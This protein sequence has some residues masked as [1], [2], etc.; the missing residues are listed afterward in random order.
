MRSCLSNV[1]IRMVTNNSFCRC[2]SS[3]SGPSS[4]PTN[5]KTGLEGMLKESYVHP[6]SQ[7]VLEHL[8]TNVSSKFIIKAFTIFLFVFIVLHTRS[9]LKFNSF[10]VLLF[11]PA[12]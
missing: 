3:S 9:M 12:L 4:G 5:A 7:I 1:P 11:A 8:Q 2:L 10:H 6:L